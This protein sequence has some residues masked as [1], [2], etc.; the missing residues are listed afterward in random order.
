MK[1]WR[2][3]WDAGRLA[4]VENCGYP[5]PNRSH[6]E[7]MDIW[8]AGQVGSPAPWAGWARAADAADAGD[9]CYVGDGAA[10]Q[11]CRDG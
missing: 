3:L 8:H 5:Q 1:S 6:F 11:R 9:L 10:P 4:I 2:P 7:S